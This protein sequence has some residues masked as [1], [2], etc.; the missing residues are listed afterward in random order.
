MEL[1]LIGLQHTTPE[2]V[3]RY[4]AAYPDDPTQ[5]DLANWDRFEKAHP[6]TFAQMIRFWCRKRQVDDDSA[7]ALV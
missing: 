1:E 2:P 4:R 6:K 7:S 3:R 5:T